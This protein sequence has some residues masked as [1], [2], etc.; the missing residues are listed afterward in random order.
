MQAFFERFLDNLPQIPAVIIALFVVFLVH[1]LGHYVAARWRGMRVESFSVGFGRKL[2]SVSDRYGTEWIFRIFPLG[3]HVEIGDLVLDDTSRARRS[4][5]ARLFVVLAGP[6]ANLVTPLMVFPVFFL[7]AGLPVR[8]PVIS[9]VELES[10]AA[11][12]GLQRGDVV[13]EVNGKKILGYDDLG[14]LIETSEGR[15]LTLTFRRSGVEEKITVTP[16]RDVYKDVSN[17]DR[18]QFRI[19]VL[20]SNLPFPLEFVHRVNGVPTTDDPDRA[21]AEILK[22]LG[23]VVALG[24]YAA[25][26][27]VHI[28]NVPIP[29]DLNA[30]L[31]D[32]DHKYYDK[33]YLGPLRDNAFVPLTFG[34]AMQRGITE[35]VELYS[36]IVKVPLQIFPMDPK[37][38]AERVPFFPETDFYY[39]SL[40]YRAVY[41]AALI[42]IVIGLFNLLPLPRLDGSFILSYGLEG[43][44]RRPPTR[45]ERAI[46]MAVI[47]FSLYSLMLFANLEDLPGYIDL[48]LEDLQKEIKKLGKD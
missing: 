47:I 29:A 11:L 46:G 31:R 13:I 37:L 6:L 22:T 23:Q 38:F 8:P 4:V 39:E 32:K 27:E 25:D 41:T 12:A 19:G 35:A 44:R 7:L 14:D 1:E 26:K 21:R 30:H 33:I 42:S 24:L 28:Y 2:W 3:G 18:D 48:K 15:P 16:K 36:Y 17:I 9:A 45:R 43:L 20:N 40:I 5:G 10:P 34:E